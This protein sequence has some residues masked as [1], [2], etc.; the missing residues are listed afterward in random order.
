[1]PLQRQRLA[2]PPHDARI[3]ATGQ[4]PGIR[5]ARSFHE[6]LANPTE[7]VN[8]HVKVACGADNGQ[9]HAWWLQMRHHELERC[10]CCEAVLHQHEMSSLPGRR[11]CRLAEADDA[12]GLHMTPNNYV[13]KNGRAVIGC[14]GDWPRKSFTP[15]LGALHLERIWNATSPATRPEGSLPRS[16]ATFE[17]ARARRSLAPFLRARRRERWCAPPT[18]TDRPGDA[19][20]PWIGLRPMPNCPTQLPNVYVADFSCQALLLCLCRHCWHTLVHRLVT[21]HMC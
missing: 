21:V 2:E 10:F 11:R 19:D 13:P 6:A 15:I 16:A 4:N 3:K 8:R 12:T 18:R 5:Q 17:R 20:K 7:L 1:M 9:Q 14:W